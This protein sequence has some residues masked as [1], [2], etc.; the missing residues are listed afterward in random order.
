ML[1]RPD[2]LNADVTAIQF[3]QLIL[4]PT[5]PYVLW[6]K[7]PARKPFNEFAGTIEELSQKQVDWDASGAAVYHA[8]ASFKLAQKDPKGTKPAD[9]RLGRTQHNIAFIC[10]FWLDIDAGQAETGKAPK[11]YPN[12]RAAVDALLAFCQSVGLPMPLLVSSGNGVHAYWPLDRALSPDEWKIYASG[13]KALC[14]K[15]NLHADPARTA[16]VSSVLRTPGTHNRKFGE[17]VVKCFRLVGPYP[18]EHFSILKQ[19]GSTARQASASPSPNATPF[20]LGPMP[21]HLHGRQRRDLNSLA[22]TDTRPPVLAAAAADQC[23]QLARMRDEWGRLPEPLWYAALGVL[24]FCADGDAVGHAWSAGYDGYSHEETQG[25]LDRARTLSGATTCERFHSLN[26]ALCEACPLWGKIKS[27]IVLG[28]QQRATSDDDRAAPFERKEESNEDAEKFKASGAANI[29]EINGTDLHAEGGCAR[30]NVEEQQC[31]GEGV[32]LKDFHAYM[33]RHT[34]MFAPTGELWPASS[35]NARVALIHG[36]D[37]KGRPKLTPA[38]EWLDQ[39]RAV[40]QMTWAPGLPVLIQNRLVAEGGWIERKD[41]TC[42]NLYR[43]PIIEPGNAAEAGPWVNHVRKVFAVHAD[44]IINWLAQRVQRPQEKINHALVLG[45]NQGIGKDTL[46]EPAKHGVGHWNF[47][48]I[49]P[50]HLLGRFNGFV[51]SVILR[52]NEARD[53]GDVNR[54]EFYDHMKAYTAAPPDVLRVDEKNLR[55]HGVFNCCGVI[56]TTNHKADGIYLPADDRRHFVAWSDL[57]KDDFVLGYWSSLWRWYASGGNRHVAAFLAELDIS[58]FD[59]K[60]PPPKT[61]AFWDIVDASRAPEDAE[62]ADIIDKLGNPDATT[63][64]QVANKAS[65]DFAAWIQDRRNRRAIPHRFEKCGYVPVRNDAAKD[66]MWKINNVRQ[67]IYAK[68][69]LSIRDRL[70]VTDELVKTRSQDKGQ[71]SK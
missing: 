59:P 32:S 53:L 11:P 47:C 9:K 43:P 27:P 35:V 20:D 57:T 41:V 18:L 17:R 37:G 50:K 15:H 29:D 61:A 56:I 49:S 62:L 45:G 46:L 33:P 13:L 65:C 3:L 38:S 58:S 12:A 26:P 4:P 1:S 68:S 23:R 55:E 66:G 22:A 2:H 71:A 40:E 52:V 64:V 34:Y 36:L 67:R 19:A 24:A 21:A 30:A 39:N 51:K 69:A 25:R 14:V 60:A 31:A 16:D 28:R 48:E 63:I 8:C 70:K 6:V 7:P 10:S 54:F 44:H 42:F 5:G